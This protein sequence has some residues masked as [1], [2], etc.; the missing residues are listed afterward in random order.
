MNLIPIEI[1]AV[2]FCSY[3]KACSKIHLQVGRSD[4]IK[5]VGQ[6]TTPSDLLH[7]VTIRQGAAGENSSGQIGSPLK[8]VQQHSGAKTL[9]ILP[10]QA[11]VKKLLNFPLTNCAASILPGER[12]GLQKATFRNW[13]KAFWGSGSNR[14]RQPFGT[15]ANPDLIVTVKYSLLGEFK[16]HFPHVWCVKK[17]DLLLGPCQ[18]HTTPYMLWQKCPA[19]THVTFTG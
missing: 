15:G 13:R 16:R 14:F 12:L 5:M 2:Y 8:K 6:E 10:C 18:A 17:H 9:I 3:R 4:M 1:T 11:K 19:R 7:G